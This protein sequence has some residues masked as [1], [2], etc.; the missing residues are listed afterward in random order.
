MN[1]YLAV[2]MLALGLSATVAGVDP[3]A[4]AQ[5]QALLVSYSRSHV[6]VSESVVR[7]GDLFTN[8]GA[9]AGNSVD[10]APHPGSEMV[11]DVHRLAAIARAHGLVWQAQ[12]WSERV[13]VK[14]PGQTIN[15]DE[16][17]AAI[18]AALEV[19][20]L[21]G[22][23][24]LVLSN[25]RPRLSVPLDQPAIP[26]VESLQFRE[27]TGR[28]IAVVTGGAGTAGQPRLTVSGRVHRLV[29]IPTLDRRLK[30]GDIIRPSDIRWVTMRADHI[31]RNVITDAESLIGMTPMRIVPVGKIM[32]DGD[33]RRPRMVKKGSIVTMV[34]TT[35][36]MVLTSKGRAMEHG[37][38]GDTI[39]IMN[40]KSKAMIEAEVTGASSVRITPIFNPPTISAARK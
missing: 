26:K 12:S 32:R 39:K 29:D 28:F 6:T 2:F 27:R 11:Y 5:Q 7:L 15:A 4:A 3:G 33:V 36:H 23:W 8:T 9:K 35:P 34:L 17:R 24:Q 22:K 37:A 16:I 10:R 1:R 30:T 40:L 14:R 20:G 19:K 18:N 21:S 13:V 31:T 25:R 38:R